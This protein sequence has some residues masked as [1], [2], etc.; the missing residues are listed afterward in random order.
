M[1][2][3]ILRSSLNLTSLPLALSSAAFNSRL[4]TELLTSPILILFLHTTQ[5]PLFYF[6][7]WQFFPFDLSGFGSE[8][9]RTKYPKNVAIADLI[10]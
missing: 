5:P 6:P 7:Q 2:F 8:P 9:R 10:L 4:K 3:V 1:Q